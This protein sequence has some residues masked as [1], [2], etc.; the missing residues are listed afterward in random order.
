LEILRNMVWAAAIIA[1]DGGRRAGASYLFQ[2]AT[3]QDSTLLYKI[4]ATGLP[5]PHV[6]D[7][8]GK[9]GPVLKADDLFPGTMR[10]LFH[11]IWMIIEDSQVPFLRGVFAKMSALRGPMDGHLQRCI[12]AH[13]HRLPTSYVHRLMSELLESGS[14][15]SLGGAV[16]LA[17]QAYWLCEDAA[18]R[19]IAERMAENIYNW[20]W[21][22][23]MPH[24][25]RIAIC[26]EVMCAVR[27]WTP[28]RLDLDV[29]G[30]D[31]ATRLLLSAADNPEA[32]AGKLEDF[33]AELTAR[34][35][36]REIPVLSEAALPAKSVETLL[37]R[38]V[39]PMH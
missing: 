21:L 36:V 29:A 6:W 7:R 8:K 10:L 24:P 3:G 5:T 11:P 22:Q 19:M 4:L 18:H 15:D 30:E 32:M 20:Q 27:R 9:P 35:D 26:T 12:Q 39:D 1:M 13:D 14:L 23:W 17:H 16:L 34:P 38:V 31:A 25:L 37:A 33:W 28:S 2:T